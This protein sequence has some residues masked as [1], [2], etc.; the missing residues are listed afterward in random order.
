[1]RC[2]RTWG[3]LILATVAAA[4]A[5]QRTEPRTPTPQ[6]GPAPPA[7]AA[8]AERVRIGAILPQSADATMR[9]YGELVREG[10]DIAFAE[11]A[12]PVELIVVDDGGNPQR[13][14]SLTRDLEGR[15]VVAI[16]GPLLGES[17]DASTAARTDGSLAVISPTSSDPPQGENAYTLNSGDAR[18]AE[19]LARYAVARGLRDVAILYPEGPAFTD[20]VARFR[21]AMRAAGGRI[22]A[23]VAWAAGTTTFATPL[24]Q[25][26]T[27]R[28]RAV[29]VPASERDIL[30][31]APQFAYYGLGNVQIL[32]TEAWAGEEVLSRLPAR[33][34]EGVVAA[35]PFLRT[36]PAVAWDE[37]VGKY[38]AA[39]RRTLDTPYPALGYDAARL[40]LAAVDQ[41]RRPSRATVARHL[42]ETQAH[43]GA[44][45]VLSL[46]DGAV[47]RQPFLVRIQNSRPQLIPDPER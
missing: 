23:E 2:V 43:R 39:Q 37:F 30:Q 36:S 22:V 11:S 35:V 16:I 18:G 40:V 47:T 24:Q 8:D 7:E 29:F 21:S 33:E 5:G 32:G 25:L 14:A 12:R 15:G 41:E 38:E 13:A 9:Q 42:A 4:C 19:A 45:G 27:S 28:A 1:L 17:V 3:G 26:R 44:T 34:M 31:L 10:L 46:T 6:P 20:Q